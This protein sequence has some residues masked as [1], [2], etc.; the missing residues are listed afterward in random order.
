MAYEKSGKTSKFLSNSRIDLMGEKPAD[1][2]LM[3]QKKFK[4]TSAPKN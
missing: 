2:P 1:G 4:Q 3:P